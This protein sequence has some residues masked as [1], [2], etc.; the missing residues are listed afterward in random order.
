MRPAVVAILLSIVPLLLLAPQG[1]DSPEALKKLGLD[2]QEI[3]RIKEIQAAADKTIAEVRVE[4]NL[5]KARLEKLLFDVNVDM[6]EVE[7]LLRASMEWKLKAELAEIKRRVELRKLF[8][9]E[10]WPRFLRALKRWRSR[11]RA[12]I[13]GGEGK[14]E[15]RR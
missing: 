13:P 10:R 11:D 8:G 14:P 1:V 3:E 7:K 12:M 5:L 6:R 2:D 15:T 9:E 4:L